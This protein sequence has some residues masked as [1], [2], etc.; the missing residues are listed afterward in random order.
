MEL[1]ELQKLIALMNDND[2]VEVEIEE[3]ETKIRLKKAGAAMMQAPSMMG[4]AQP[5]MHPQ[6]LAPMGSA[7]SEGAVEGDSV[8]FNSP[9]VGT[10]YTAASPGA[11]QFVKIGDKVGHS[12]VLCII[13]AM[14]VM[15][16]IQAEMDGEILEVLVGN[17]EAVE[18][19]QP[20]FTLRPR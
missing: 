13:E 17:G 18:Y 14:K 11:E 8:T 15:N 1:E 19:G 5:M 7:A 12:T 4:Y 20:L 3:G 2:L 6:T 16:E 9:M 10:F